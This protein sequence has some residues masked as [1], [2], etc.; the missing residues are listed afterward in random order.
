[1]GPE[2]KLVHLKKRF[3]RTSL[4]AY[5]F[6]PGN[7]MMHRD[8]LQGISQKISQV[9]P[10]AASARK[11]VQAKAYE[12]LESAFSSLN[13]VTRE[14][15]DAQLKVLSRAETTIA[16]LERKISRLEAAHDV[17]SSAGQDNEKK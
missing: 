7:N 1:M 10:G 6:S 2:Y 3:P 4:M 11:E 15:F 17:R 9:I 12:V 16:E 8:F 13:L 5:T 14:E